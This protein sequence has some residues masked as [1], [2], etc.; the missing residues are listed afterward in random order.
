MQTVRPKGAEKVKVAQSCPALCNPGT[1]QSMDFSR[2]EYWS[3]WPYP[4]PGDL[5]NSGIKPRSP[6]LRADSSPAEP[7]EKPKTTGMGSLSPHQRIFPTQESDRGLLHCRRILYQ[8]S[9]Q[10]GSVININIPFPEYESVHR[11]SFADEERQLQKT[12]GES[13]CAESKLSEAGQAGTG[14]YARRS[15]GSC[16]HV[17]LSPFTWHLK[18]VLLPAPSVSLLPNKLQMPQESSFCKQYLSLD[19]NTSFQSLKFISAQMMFMTL[20]LVILSWILS[21]KET[22]LAHGPRH[23]WLWTEPLLKE[24]WGQMELIYSQVE[25]SHCCRRGLGCLK[26]HPGPGAEGKIISRVSAQAVSNQPGPTT[27]RS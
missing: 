18:E 13:N 14:G 12:G 11:Y 25:E 23:L 21:T 19:I 9:Y 22:G 24:G 15:Q 10:G 1:I 20:G 8:L 16:H 26:E 3:G 6:T 5:P 17:A 2:P 4:S 27:E 7:H